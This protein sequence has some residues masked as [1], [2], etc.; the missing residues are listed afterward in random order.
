[1]IAVKPCAA[2]SMLTPCSACTAVRAAAVGLADVV[3]DDGGASGIEHAASFGPGGA[4]S[5]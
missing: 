3:E 1:M 5:H 4:R 2:N